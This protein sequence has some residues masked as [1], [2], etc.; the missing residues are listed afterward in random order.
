MLSIKLRAYSKSRDFFQKIKNGGISP[1][2]LTKL[3]FDRNV[4]SEFPNNNNDSYC[5][6]YLP[7]SWKGEN[8]TYIDKSIDFYAKTGYS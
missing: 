2:V 6:F 3:S 8:R 4:N 7:K 1:A 5:H